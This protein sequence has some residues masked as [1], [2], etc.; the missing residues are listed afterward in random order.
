MNPD[1]NQLLTA[2]EGAKLMDLPT[3][4]IRG[5]MRRKELAALKVGRYLRIPRSEITKASKSLSHRAQSSAPPASAK[6]LSNAAARRM[7]LACCRHRGEQ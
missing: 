2:R 5:M 6:T 4:V 7:R 3:K 1:P